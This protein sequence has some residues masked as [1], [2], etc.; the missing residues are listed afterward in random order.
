MHPRRRDRRG[1]G[2]RG[3]LTPVGLPVTRSRAEQFDEFVLDAVE[4]LERRWAEELRDVEFAVEDVPPV[5]PAPG[6][7]TGSGLGRPG[8][9]AGGPGPIDSPEG[10]VA[11]GRAFAVAGTRPARVVVYRRAIESRARGQ[12]ALGALVH[13]VLVEQVAELLG[14]EPEAIDPEYGDGPN[15]GPDFGPDSGPDGSHGP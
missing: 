3:P 11:L 10:I 14:R 5:T 9:D 6:G 2:L 4:R 7:P 8:P 12:R 15:F 1:R 13:D